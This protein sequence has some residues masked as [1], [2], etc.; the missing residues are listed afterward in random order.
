MRQSPKP[1]SYWDDED[2]IAD[3]N[4]HGT[5]VFVTEPDRWT[6]LYDANGK[7]ILRDKEPIGFRIR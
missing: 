7:R 2:G 4:V 6:G 5:E 3:T 1:R